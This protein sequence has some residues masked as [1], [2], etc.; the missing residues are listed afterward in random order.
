MTRRNHNYVHV[1]N[2]ANATTT[3]TYSNQID[4][5]AHYKHGGIEAIDVIESWGLGFHLGNV[6][7]YVSRAG[8][9]E[10]AKEDL[11]KAQ[12]YLNRY[13]ERDHDHR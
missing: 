7:K 8:H 6:I 2:T 9:K 12:W 3:V 10:D 1:P 13:L 11:K 5:P 4:H